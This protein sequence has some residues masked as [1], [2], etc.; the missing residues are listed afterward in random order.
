MASKYSTD[1]REQALKHI[2]KG[3]NLAEVSRLMNIPP[4]TIFYWKKSELISLG[5]TG[6][7][8]R[9]ID[10]FSQLH[11]KNHQSIEQVKTKQQSLQIHKPTL[12]QEL[13]ALGL[14]GFME[15]DA[16]LSTQYKSYL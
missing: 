4:S 7:Q 1:V 6:S 12:Y 9:F 2:A 3:K 14:I 16:N 13:E 5:A 15:D 8:I 11:V 10:P